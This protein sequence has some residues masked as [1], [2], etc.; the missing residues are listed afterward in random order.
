MHVIPFIVFERFEPIWFSRVAHSY[1]HLRWHQCRRPLDQTRFL[2]LL[3]AVL[4]LSGSA[5]VREITDIMTLIVSSVLSIGG[6]FGVAIALLQALILLNIQQLSWYCKGNEVV[7]LSAAFSFCNK[8]TLQR[9]NAHTGFD[10]LVRTAAFSAVLLHSENN[11][12]NCD[13]F[14]IWFSHENH[15]KTSKGLSPLSAVFPTEGIEAQRS[16]PNG[17]AM[18]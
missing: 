7:S 10:C 1:H 9:S 16:F 4:R 6:A 15:G 14:S 5:P 18:A 8:Q 13:E 3:V 2:H 17:R 12:T 11:I